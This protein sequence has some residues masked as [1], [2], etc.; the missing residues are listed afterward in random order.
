MAPIDGAV[1]PG[2]LEAVVAAVSI[3]GGAMAYESGL[4]AAEAVSENQPAETLGRRVN[5]GIAKGFVP[6]LAPIGNRAYHRAVGVIRFIFSFPWGMLATSTSVA[7]A[8]GI[9]IIAFGAPPAI[10]IPVGWAGATAY[11]VLNS[12]VERQLN[13]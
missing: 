13:R 6:G 5:E 10:L 11:R 1:V 12:R 3:L 4:G 8:T 7:I 2:L 9:A